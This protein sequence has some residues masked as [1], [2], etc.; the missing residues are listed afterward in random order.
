MFR[1]V[2]IYIPERETQDMQDGGSGPQQTDCLAHPDNTGRTQG[3][4]LPAPKHMAPV[5]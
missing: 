3:L 2:Y 4:F 5:R 1:H